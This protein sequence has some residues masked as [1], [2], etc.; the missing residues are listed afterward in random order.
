MWI[1]LCGKLAYGSMCTSEK[2]WVDQSLFA[3]LGAALDSLSGC[4]NKTLLVHSNFP[5]TRNDTVPLG[6]ELQFVDEGVLTANS[7]YTV[8]IL[9]K[10]SS[11][12]RQI[13]GSNNLTITFD[14]G[15][16]ID[17]VIPQWWG[18]IVNDDLDDASAIQKAANAMYPARKTLYFPAGKYDVGSPIV[19]EVDTALSQRI[20]IVGYHAVIQSTTSNSTGAFKLISSV[21]DG[22]G[23]ANIDGG[24]YV[25]GLRF[26]GHGSGYGLYIHGAQSIFLKDLHVEQFDYGLKL[27]SVDL[28][29]ISS[30]KIKSNGTGILQKRSASSSTLKGEAGNEF[31]ISGNH[32][33][34]NDT[35]I[36]FQQGHSVNIEN[37][38]FSTTEFIAIYIGEYENSPYV[39]SS[40]N[41]VTI[42]KN[43]FESNFSDYSIWIG[44][45]NVPVKNLVIEKNDF[46]SAGSKA[47]YLKNAKSFGIIRDNRMGGDA[48]NIEYDSGG[49]GLWA[50]VSTAIPV[51]SGDMFVDGTNSTSSKIMFTYK[52]PN[53]DYQIIISPRT[54]IGG[55]PDN[56]GSFVVR[57]IYKY[58]DGFELQVHNPPGTGRKVYFNWLLLQNKHVTNNP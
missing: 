37:N 25:S 40:L 14:W 28:A 54:Y 19:I 55:M 12:N 32:F 45:D 43:R 3:N 34:T 22:G 53:A 33:S 51:Q 48:T 18:A 36:V 7:P 9:G 10:I 49:N 41:S 21:P 1:I 6:I 38:D 4:G 5:V 50:I 44:N 20:N 30:C 8:L 17:Q 13:F 42:S 57:E 47:I 27:F 39:D 15:T 11:T 24:I 46:M 23:T 16:A 56:L 2:P 26:G 35:D 58:A 52:Q 31:S 29:T